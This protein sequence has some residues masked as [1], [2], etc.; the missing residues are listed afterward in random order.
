MTL[1]PSIEKEDSQSELDMLA[2][3]WESLG[4]CW[5]LEDELLESDGSTLAD[6]EEEDEAG[7]ML[8]GIGKKF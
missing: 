5:V 4:M 1:W 8:R 7:G 3:G 6:G 2:L